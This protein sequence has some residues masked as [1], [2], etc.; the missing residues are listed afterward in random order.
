MVEDVQRK[1]NIFRS[2]G[3]NSKDNYSP[4][5]SLD[6]CTYILHDH[7]FVIAINAIYMVSS[8]VPLVEWNLRSSSF[9]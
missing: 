8:D 3:D 4:K 7:R 6:L 2:R 5:I 1:L 9:P